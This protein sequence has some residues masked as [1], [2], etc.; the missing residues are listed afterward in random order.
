MTEFVGRMLLIWVPAAMVAHAE[1]WPRWLGTEGTG[2]TTETEWRPEV[3]SIRWQTEIGVG[4]SSAAVVGDRVVVSGYVA[5]AEVIWCLSAEDG[6]VLWSLRYA[7]PLLPNLH[8]GGPAS[9]ALIDAGKVYAL[10]K[11]GHLHCLGLEEGNVLWSVNLREMSGLRTPP[12]WGYA[13]SPILVDDK[14]IVESSETWALDPEDG[15]VIWKSEPYKPAY[16]T[17]APLRLGAKTFLAT[18]KTDGLVILDAADGRSKALT[19]W[20]T[21]FQTNANTPIVVGDQLFLSTGY[22]RGCG[23]FRFTGGE[24]VP[25]YEGKTMS[26][27][28]NNSI[29]VDG[30][31]YG[32]DGTAHRGAP[33]EMTCIEW[34]TGE[35]QWRQGGLGCGSLL[36]GNGHLV[37]LTETGDLVFAKTSP[38]GYE[39]VSRT[40]IL[41][42]RCW[43]MPTFANGVV[44]ARNAAGR[45]VGV[46][47]KSGL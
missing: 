8:E 34:A 46:T 36:E 11:A 38:D 6:L 28:M 33:A 18:L 19:V 10:G 30:Y 31:L 27:H 21:S 7:A 17:P 9:T 3:D 13:G 29:L 45:M 35:T 39:E 12:Q 25:L 23:L 32:F 4:F 41:S 43:T 22:G 15:S 1:D 5:E 47:L 20:R 44:Y 37:I 2:R 24:L 26:N 14:L 16:G 42:G 40:S